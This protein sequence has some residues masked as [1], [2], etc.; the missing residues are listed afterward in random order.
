MLSLWPVTA[1]LFLAPSVLCHTISDTT[2]VCLATYNKDFNNELLLGKW[3][4]VYKFS[5]WLNLPPSRSCNEVSFQ[6]P[7]NEDLNNYKNYFNKNDMPYSFEDDS[8][9]F[10][11]LNTDPPDNKFFDG[12]FLG[13]REA[14]FFVRHPVNNANRET[15]DVRVFRYINDEYLIHED[16]A[17][18]GHT[19]WLISRKRNP[20]DEELQKIIASQYDLRRLESQKHCSLI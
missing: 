11:V 13:G 20:T 18:R 19:R 6:R 12:L 8:I 4:Y 9:A 14:K 1:L 7:T 15:Y 5:I 3:Y 10:S 16:C 2:R 17:L